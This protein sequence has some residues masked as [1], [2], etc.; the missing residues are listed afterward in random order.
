MVRGSGRCE[1]IAGQL[2]F[3]HLKNPRLSFTV[4]YARDDIDDVDIANE[5]GRGVTIHRGDIVLI[6]GE[7]SRRNYVVYASKQQ[8][9]GFINRDM[10]API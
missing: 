2:A 8:V 1:V 4:L 10:L 3:V 9:I 7:A 5:I 6:L